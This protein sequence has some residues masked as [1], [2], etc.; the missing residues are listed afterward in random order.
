VPEE[1]GV[2]REVIEV[3][4][5][6][7]V[8]RPGAGG[9]WMP[10]GF[11]TG[12]G[13]F[14]LYQEPDAVVLIQNGRLR[15]AAV[16]YTRSHDQVQILD[17]AKHMYFSTRTFAPPEGGRMRVEWEQ[18]AQIVN[19]RPG[20]LYDGFVS[21]HL[22][23][24]GRGVAAN[25]FVGNEVLATVHARLPFPGVNVARSEAGPRFFAWFDELEGKTA[26]GE[27]HAYAV[28]YDSPADTLTWRMDGEVVKRA[29]AVGGF[30]PVNLAIGLMTETDIVPGK[31]SV[32]CHGQGAVGSWGAIR[33]VL[34]SAQ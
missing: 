24:L 3:A 29:E 15:V 9:T 28:E 12:D 20:D 22:L 25:F 14:W 21:F 16:P 32:S 5:F 23:D 13:G 1:A 30:G 6:G 31:G 8:L 2:A 10:G 19:G 33:V 18:S 7:S 26:P 27:T 34:E 11:P 4:E 17:N